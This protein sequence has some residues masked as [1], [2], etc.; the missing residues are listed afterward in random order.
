MAVTK[1][2]LIDERYLSD[3]LTNVPIELVDIVV[4]PY[5]RFEIT[6]KDRK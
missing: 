3:A 2:S 4:I 6:L 5:F 1:S